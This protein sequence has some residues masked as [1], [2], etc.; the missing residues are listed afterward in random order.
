MITKV[1]DLQP[2]T[3]FLTTGDGSSFLY[4]GKRITR[5]HDG[6]Y[7]DGIFTPETTVFSVRKALAVCAA[8][9]YRAGR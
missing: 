8:N 9:E 7:L 4:D 5:L 3:Y 1:K 6:V 2:G